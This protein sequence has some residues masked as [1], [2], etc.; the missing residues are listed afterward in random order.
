[1]PWLIVVAGV[2]KFMLWAG[3]A[4]G[5]GWGAWQLATNP[6][7]A[8]TTVLGVLSWLIQYFLNYFN[9]NIGF[10]PAGVIAGFPIV[11]LM[12]IGLAELNVILPVMEACQA[13]LFLIAAKFFAAVIV[14][15]R[16]AI[17][18]VRDGG[19]IASNS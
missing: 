4:A 17:G 15:V 7:A 9:A 8:M 2:V 10:T 3:A 18:I 6:V 12:V 13:G 16:R 11:R 5:I 1:M 19:V 14:S